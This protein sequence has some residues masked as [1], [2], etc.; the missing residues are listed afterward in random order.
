M[1]AKWSSGADKIGTDTVNSL[2]SPASAN[3]LFSL[4]P[5]RGLISRG[6]IIP[7]LYTQDIIGPIARNVKDLAV[8]LTVM[9]SN[10]FDP[11]DN[12]TSLRPP[13]LFGIDYFENVMGGRFQGLRFGL[14]EGFFNR[15]P[16]SETTPINNVMDH[17]ASVLQNAGVEIIPIT[18]AVYNCTA[19][20]SFDVQTSE[21]RE[22]MNAYLQMQSLGGSRPSTLGRLYSS[23]KFL[24]I[25]SQ[26]GF[27]ETALHSS[28]NNATYAP[29]KLDIQNLTAVLRTTFVANGL[30][31]II[32]PEQKNLV[33]KIG[34]P[35]QSGRNGI[36][37]ALTGSPVLTVP[38]G[39]SPPTVDA[40]IGVPIGMKILG[41]PWSESTLINIAS[42]ISTFTHVRHMPTFANKSVEVNSY[43][44][45][46]LVTPNVRNILSAYPIGV[47]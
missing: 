23:R 7:V 21:F 38:A 47:Y 13:T 46:P 12:T 40:P 14:L 39:F 41:L 19:L 4:R 28:T 16:S 22:T 3:S 42:Q 35:S 24:T 11:L 20:A 44:L 8:A 27:V 45:V 34:S 30:D 32:Y 36:L 29:T 26:Y 43:S 31:A 25:P 1:I 15:T 5:T 17:M 6:G 18:E 37:A 33:V 2:R 10:G 9:A